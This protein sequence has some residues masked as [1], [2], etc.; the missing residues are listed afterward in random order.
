MKL[1]NIV[2]INF[3]DCCQYVFQRSRMYHYWTELLEKLDKESEE[4][5]KEY[6]L[7]ILK[8]IA[9]HAYEN[10]PF[11]KERFDTYGFNPYRIQSVD[12]LQILPLLNKNEVKDNFRRMISRKVYPFLLSKGFTSGTTGTPGVFLRDLTSVTFE[13]AMIWHLRRKAGIESGSKVVWLR[14]DIIVSQLRNKPPFWI[15]TYKNQLRVSTYHLFAEYKTL[16]LDVIEK[17]GPHCAFAYPSAAYILALWCR[18][19]DRYL[20]FRNLNTSSES[21]LFIHKKIISE[22]LKGQWLD[23]YGQAERVCLFAT[24]DG[25]D[26]KIYNE[27]G[28]TEF[29]PISSGGFEIIGTSLHNYAM[30]LFRYRTGDIVESY[31]VTGS[32]R[33]IIKGLA[34]RK[35]DYIILPD[36]RPIGRLDLIFKGLNNIVEGQIYQP[37]LEQIIIRIVSMPAYSEKDEI[38]LI[39]NARERLGEDVGIS[40]QH[41][42]MISRSNSGKFKFVISDITFSA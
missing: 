25:D 12:G 3:R 13:H 24:L 28:V 30:P 10:I 27:Y 39:K 9:K 14:G 18:E 6:Q 42:N 41:V 1:S 16:I 23:H 20:P 2:K 8:K 33:P 19:T 31:H 17:Y 15:K 4:F 11:W 35:E 40:I 26:Y 5:R 36:G 29:Y 32:E 22:R 7:S 37:Y 34:G 21:V 38:R